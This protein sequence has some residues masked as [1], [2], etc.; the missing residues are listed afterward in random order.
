MTN[1]RTVLKGLSATLL[2][3]AALPAWAKTELSLGDVSF[4]SVSDGYLELPGAFF[5]QGLP[6]DQVQ[7]I[8][9]RHGASA[10]RL[11]PPCNLTLLRHADR[12]VLF[13]AGAGSGFMESAGNLLD[14]LED[15]G[16]APDEVTHVVFTHGH[17]DH[18]WGVLDD[19]DDPVFP[20]ATHM[21]GVE[22]FDYWR[23][24]DTVNS[25]GE[26]RASFA[27]GAARRL[28][29]IEDALVT[30]RAGEEILPGVMAHSS[31]GHTPGHMAFEVRAGSDSVMI[32][33]DAIGNHHVAV[34]RPEWPS[35]S[36]QDPQ[37]A[38]ATRQ[39]LLDQLATDQMTFIGFH[40]PGGGIGRIER[41]GDAYRFV[42]DG[43]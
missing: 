6:Q 29:A 9:S 22:E 20:N 1:R 36:D 24:P 19:F 12:T 7:D 2:S 39:R 25:I 27:V 3:G 13:D 14:S 33:G 35:G 43:G 26:A 16:V 28:G 11:T 40:L 37:T 23:D 42:S 31:F 4:L 18:L 32:A 41:S 17:P 5:F 10:E 15:A 8:L 30:F 38:A 21:M 34:E